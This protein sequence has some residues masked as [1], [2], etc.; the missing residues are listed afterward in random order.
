MITAAELE[1]EVRRL[2]AERPDFVYA[3]PS[4]TTWGSCVYA[5]DGC[6]SCIMG[7]ALINVGI[8]VEWF[9]ESGTRNTWGIGELISLLHFEER[10]ADDFDRRATDW[11][12]DVQTQQDLSNKW[13]DAI[14]RAD[15]IRA[16]A[17]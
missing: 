10:I 9:T 17:K 13:S 12:S 4:G 8:P 15:E 1:A 11:F 3:R 6:G 16:R 14:A 2:A 5:H 7:Q